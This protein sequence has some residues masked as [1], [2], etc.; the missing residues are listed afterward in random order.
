MQDDDRIVYI[1]VGWQV[2]EI[3]YFI[4]VGLLVVLI[5]GGEFVVIGDQNKVFMFFVFFLS[6]QGLNGCSDVFFIVVL[7]IVFFIQEKGSVV[8]DL[9]YLFDVDGFQGNDLIIFVNYFFQKCSIVDWVFCIVLFFS[10]FCVCDDG[11]LLV[12]IYLCD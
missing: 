6:F 2:N 7:N 4:D 11:K 8:W 9:V 5:F 1:Y 3:C 10:V 12:L